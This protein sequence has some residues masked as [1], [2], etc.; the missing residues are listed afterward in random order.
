MFSA[1]DLQTIE[2]VI[3]NNQPVLE[4]LLSRGL[5]PSA[6]YPAAL[7]QVATKQFERQDGTWPLTVFAAKHGAA[8]TLALLLDRGGALPGEH[9]VA[10]L[11]RIAGSLPHAAAARAVSAILRR[12]EARSSPDALGPALVNAAGGGSR[13]VVEVLLAAGVPLNARD[14]KGNTVLHRAIG[15]YVTKDA[16]ALITWLCELKA[17]VD[18]L[19]DE[20]QLPLS[21]ALRSGSFEAALA[22]LRAGSPGTGRMTPASLGALESAVAKARAL[23]KSP[24]D[25]FGVARLGAWDVLVELAEAGMRL[26][27]QPMIGA[28]PWFELLASAPLELQVRALPLLDDREVMLRVVASKAL[29]EQGLALLEAALSLGWD[30]NLPGASEPPR[31]P[32]VL[33]A[34]LAANALQAAEVLVA[35]GASLDG[36]P[37]RLTPAHGLKHRAALTWLADRGGALDV[38]VEPV[39]TPLQVAVERGFDDAILFL[40]GAGVRGSVTNAANETPLEVARRRGASAKVLEALEA[41]SV[42]RVAVPEAPVEVRRLERAPLVRGC[43]EG[44]LTTVQQLVASGADVNALDTRGTTPLTAAT[45]HGR[46]DVVEALLALG[47]L[48]NVTTRSG[49]SA[50]GLASLLGHSSIQKRLVAAGANDAP[51]LLIST[52]NPLEAASRAISTGD[53]RSVAALIEAGFDVEFPLIGGRLPLAR[54]ILFKQSA[55][56]DLLLRAGASVHQPS[57]GFTAVMLA[58]LTGQADLVSRLLKEGADVEVVVEGWNAAGLAMMGEH[59]ALGAL[60]GASVPKTGSLDAI[61]RA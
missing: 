10:T 31:S 35:R 15:Q 57:S 27:A 37:G 46:E 14:G 61:K 39:G 29:N 60:F 33:G 13:P 53:Q 38:S 47:A 43:A 44:A 7:Y 1:P 50:W 3:R 51:V 34:A 23:Q 6:E 17:P 18:T 49:M 42:Q 12:E 55:M 16:L 8:G 26:D 28:Q 30:L 41:I 20:G 24:A 59:A 32:T 19:N 22:L 11:E 5:N 21:R 40:A 52:G 45:A 25:V 2:A 56:V 58:V 48:P 4:G 54:A 9:V 36:A